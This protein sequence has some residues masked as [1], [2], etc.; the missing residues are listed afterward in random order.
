MDHFSSLKTFFNLYNLETYH[1]QK[2][3]TL[4]LKC[5]HVKECEGIDKVKEIVVDMFMAIHACMFLKYWY[6]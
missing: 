3:K 6:S 5:N 4:L 2:C 1:F